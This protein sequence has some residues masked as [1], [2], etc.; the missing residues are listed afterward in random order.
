MPLHDT[1]WLCRNLGCPDRQ[2]K[3]PGLGD[4][5]LLL[6]W[7]RGSQPDTSKMLQLRSIVAAEFGSAGLFGMSDQMVL[8]EIARLLISRRQRAH[9]I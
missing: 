6:Q 5:T 1:W 7:L 3:I 9:R 2:A 8:A 4:E